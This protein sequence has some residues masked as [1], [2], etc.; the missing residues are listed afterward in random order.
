MRKIPTLFERE[1][2][3]H[4]VI[5]IKPNITKGMEWVIEGK[6]IATV[7]IDGSCCAII[8]GVFYKR[9]GAKKGRKA[10]EGAIPC[11][12]PD[13]IT[14]HHPHWVKVDANNP[15]D[16]W[17]VSAYKKLNDKQDGTYEAIG[18]HFQGN[19]Y[20]L[21][22]D[23]IVPHGQATIEV[24]RTFDGIKKY[25]EENY[26]EG[27]VFWLDGEPQCKIKRSDFGFSWNDH[28]KRKA[29][30]KDHRWQNVVEVKHGQ[31]VGCTCSVCGKTSPTIYLDEYTIEYDIIETDYCS[32]CGAKMDLKEKPNYCT[33]KQNKL[34][35]C[36]GCHEKC[37][38]E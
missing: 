11:C 10:P 14:G 24:E 12:E 3:N 36:E 5:G 27:I 18:K 21:I 15:S 7:K 1:Y 38:E 19:P 20:D 17:F 31:W 22:D 9:Y 28:S 23:I 35:H 26:I 13:T 8:D 4:K 25:L 34:V 32:N 6:G 30:E 33:D 16:K 29:D 37:K 2:A